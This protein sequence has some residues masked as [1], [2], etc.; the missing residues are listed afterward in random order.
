MSSTSDGYR[1]A[2]MET[3]TLRQEYFNFQL[4]RI[5]RVSE[6]CM[7]MNDVTDKSP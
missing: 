1:K 2:V 7:V 5:L 3:Q 4:P 6:A